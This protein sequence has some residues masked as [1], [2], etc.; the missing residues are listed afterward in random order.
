MGGVHLLRSDEA[1]IMRTMEELKLLEAKETSPTHCSGDKAI[2]MFENN[3]AN[4]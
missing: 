4:I 2:E 1:T 3:F